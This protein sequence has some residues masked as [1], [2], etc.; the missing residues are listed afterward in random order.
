MT[1]RFAAMPSF[2]CPNCGRSVRV[3]PEQYRRELCCPNC[4]GRFVVDPTLP[5]GIAIEDY[6]SADPPP[7]QGDGSQSQT[8]AAARSEPRRRVVFVGKSRRSALP[9]L[10]VSGL[11]AVGAAVAIV[12]AAWKAPRGP[13]SQ[14]VAPAQSVNSDITPGIALLRSGPDPETA[15]H[16]E[17]LD[18]LNGKGFQ[19][20]MVPTHRGTFYGPAVVFIP[21]TNDQ[22]TRTVAADDCTLLRGVPYLYVQKRKSAQEARDEAGATNAAFSWG[23]FIF[24]GTDDLSRRVRDALK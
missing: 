4:R 22:F 21:R 3:Q 7:V 20:D 2:G 13:A 5:T 6:D 17:L 14:G 16:R 10:A 18:Y 23:R 11:V 15:T 9:A 1:A 24:S 12:V 19:L 8:S